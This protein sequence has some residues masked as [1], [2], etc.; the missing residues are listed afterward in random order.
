MFPFGSDFAKAL[1]TELDLQGFTTALNTV[2]HKH[3][4]GVFATLGTLNPEFKDTFLKI[5]G[6]VNGT[7]NTN[8]HTGIVASNKFNFHGKSAFH[9]I[10]VRKYR[11]GVFTGVLVGIAT[12][13]WNSFAHHDRHDVLVGPKRLGLF[14]DK[15]VLVAVAVV[16]K[17]VASKRKR[18]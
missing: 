13:T 10:L 12:A 17:T 1:G 14:S 16:A 7:R 4:Q 18:R 11:F 8:G 6:Q 3:E 9:G 2:I 5:R 15:T